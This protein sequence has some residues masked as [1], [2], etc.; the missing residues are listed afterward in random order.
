[1]LCI[2]VYPSVSLDPNCELSWGKDLCCVLLGNLRA[3]N[4]CLL[5]VLGLKHTHTHTHTHNTLS[6]SLSWPTPLAPNLNEQDFSNQNID[7][8]WDGYICTYE[9]RGWTVKSVWENQGCEISHHI[10]MTVS[11]VR[12]MLTGKK[13]KEQQAQAGWQE[14]CLMARHAKVTVSQLSQMLLQSRSPSPTIDPND[15]IIKSCTQSWK[16]TMNTNHISFCL[17]HCFKIRIS[18]IFTG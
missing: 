3:H 13:I 11:Q 10:P 8:W 6:L 14:K 1:M 2:I 18:T 12:V 16:I 17:P 4:R 9:T 7:S 5:Y 15:R